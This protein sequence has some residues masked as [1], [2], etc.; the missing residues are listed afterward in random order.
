MEISDDQFERLVGMLADNRTATINL[1]I[2]IR[3]E[4]QEDRKEWRA[5]FQSLRERVDNLKLGLSLQG[6]A[7]SAIE[8]D[9]G[10]LQ[11][12][13]RKL[14]ETVALHDQSFLGITQLTKSTFDLVNSVHERIQKAALRHAPS[15][16]LELTR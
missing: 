7:L 11:A 9:L 3:A 4:L 6:A 15:D 14:S 2:E 8:A 13:A 5:E 16:T 10:K 1:G 12:S